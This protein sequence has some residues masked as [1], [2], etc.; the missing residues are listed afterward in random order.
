MVKG[1]VTE[2]GGSAGKAPDSSVEKGS[3]IDERDKST[4]PWVRIGEQVWMGAN[5]HMSLKKGNWCYDNN[6][7]SYAVYGRLY[8]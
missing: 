3:F 5:M 6:S 2:Q 8:N 1:E 7:S 4:K